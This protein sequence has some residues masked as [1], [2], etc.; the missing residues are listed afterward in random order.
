M[1]D[2]IFHRFLDLPIELRLFIWHECLPERVHEIDLP[3]AQPTF[4]CSPLPCTLKH[5]SLENARGPIIARVCRESRKVALKSGSVFAPLPDQYRYRSSPQSW[6]VRC[7]IESCWLDPTRDRIHL[8]W[9]KYHNFGTASENKATD[10]LACRT[11]QVGRGSFMLDFFPSASQTPVRRHDLFVRVQTHYGCY[12]SI[13]WTVIMRTF[14][15][16]T[17]ARTAGGHFGLLA[18]AP[19]QIVDL[20]DEARIMTFLRLG[21]ADESACSHRYLRGLESIEHALTKVEENAEKFD[22]TFYPAQWDSDDS[23]SNI[24]PPP[25]FRRIPTDSVKQR[26]EAVL[27]FMMIRD[28]M[29]YVLRA[30]P[31][32]QFRLCTKSCTD[33]GVVEAGPRCHYPTDEEQ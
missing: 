10:A 2:A 8:N 19:I 28:S 32:V 21:E 17:D 13:D 33:M 1:P 30:T 23:F 26:L 7:L 9:N 5:T 4:Q 31:S 24:G 14:V 12:D 3:M 6:E 27:A 20:C 11:A 25:K 29:E 15:I 22:P 18:D 16:H